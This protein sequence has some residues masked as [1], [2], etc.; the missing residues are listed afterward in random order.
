MINI[1]GVIL[2]ALFFIPALILTVVSVVHVYHAWRYG[3]HSPVSVASSFIFVS[4][5]VVIW[6]VV[7]WLL[8]PVDWNAGFVWET[9]TVNTTMPN[10]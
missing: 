10:I 2:K 1:P 3:G 6:A 9:P 7:W 8:S 4:G 5:L